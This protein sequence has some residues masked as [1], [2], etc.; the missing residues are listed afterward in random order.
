MESIIRM[1]LNIDFNTFLKSCIPFIIIALVAMGLNTILYLFLPKSYLPYISNNNKMIEYSKYKFK[2]N[3]EVKKTV[4]KEIKKET[5]KE[6]KLISNILLKMVYQEKNNHGW[7]IIAEKS[8]KNSMVLGIN[9]KYKNYTLKE[10]YANYVIFTKGGKNYKLSLSPEDKLT[11]YVKD[12]EEEEETYIEQVDNQYILKRG[13]INSYTKNSTKI[14]KE[15]SIKEIFKNGKID[16]FRITRIAKN[17]VFEKLG[18][19]KNDIIKSVNNIKLKS[20][21]DA[22]KIYEKTAEI[23]NMRFV[24][25]RGDE[26]VELE[27]E[28]K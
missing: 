15:I 16:G 9:E 14:W 1:N 12:D 7:I 5:K 22:F 6:Y 11:S 23:K 17:S 28:I 13:L 21:A 20:Y 3:F 24:V 26:E 25:L 10:I 8:T 27:Y 4:K 18:L 19:R 2:E